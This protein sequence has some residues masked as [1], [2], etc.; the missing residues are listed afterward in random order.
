MRGI[1]HQFW[2]SLFWQWLGSIVT[3]LLPFFLLYLLLRWGV[4]GSVLL[5]LLF[6]AGALWLA[7]TWRLWKYSVLILSSARLIIVNQLGFFDRSI[8]QVELSQVNDVSYRKRGLL[9]T[10]CNYGSVK[11]QASGV[12]SIELKSLKNPAQIQQE[13]FELQTLC[14]ENKVT[15]FSEADLFG[16]IKEIRS[17]V[18]ERRWKTISEGEWDLKQELIDEVS[19]RDNEKA[20]I[21]EQFFSRDI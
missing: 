9:Q 18:G 20:K 7:R 1:Y 4:I 12:E 21:I 10:M 2:V 17:R 5:G 11:I 3:F 8:S 15:E 6:V 19:E 16:V 13:I 14:Q